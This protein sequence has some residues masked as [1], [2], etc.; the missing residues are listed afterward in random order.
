MGSIKRREFFYYLLASQE[1]LCSMELFIYLVK[2]VSFT[3]MKDRGNVTMVYKH[4]TIDQFL[5]GNLQQ[6]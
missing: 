6:D 2:A 4:H 1:G 3:V 5:Y